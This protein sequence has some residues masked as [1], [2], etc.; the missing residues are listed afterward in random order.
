M[1]HL[2]LDHLQKLIAEGMFMPPQLE[3]PPELSWTTAILLVFQADSQHEEI[4]DVYVGFIVR[5]VESHLYT[6]DR[7]LD[8]IKDIEVNLQ[9]ACDALKAGGDPSKRCT[10]CLFVSNFRG[11]MSIPTDPPY[12]LIYPTSYMRDVEPNHFDTHN[13]PA[14][15]HLHHCVCHATLQFNNDKPKECTNYTRSCLI[16]PHGTQY[17][18]QL[19]SMILEPWN[20]QGL[21]IDSAMKE[22]YPME[23]VGDF[24]VADLIFKG[25]YGDSLLYSDAD[26]HWLRRQGIHLPAFQGEIPVPLAPSYQQGREPEVT[27]QSPHRAAASDT[28]ME[29][30]KAKALAARAV[31]NMAQ[32]AAHL[33]SKVLRLYFSQETL[34]LQRANLKWPGEVSKGTQF[35]QA[36]LFSFSCCWVRWMQTGRFSHGR[37]WHSRHHS[38]HQ[39]QHV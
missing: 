30:P 18:N 21:L 2:S 11:A 27:K 36:W 24:W 39:L 15:M 13:N 23:L 29:S 22:P 4:T 37:L 10:F 8:F 38:S 20:H 19:F 25:C 34:Q 9:A 12:Y 3:G 32:D 1:Q 33:N 16:L 28:P 14:G 31:P 26:L 6:P 35:S 17:N 5:R 7:I